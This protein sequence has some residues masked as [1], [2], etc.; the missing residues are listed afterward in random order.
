LLLCTHGVFFVGTIIVCCLDCWQVLKCVALQVL[1]M[2]CFRHFLFLLVL[3]LRKK[4]ANGW[5]EKVAR[6]ALLAQWKWDRKAASSRPVNASIPGTSATA[7]AGAVAGG[8]VSDWQDIRPTLRRVE[9]A[10]QRSAD[11]AAATG[12]ASGNT[13]SSVGSSGSSSGEGGVSTN[14]T[15]SARRKKKTKRAKRSKAASTPSSS[16]APAPA[17]RNTV[18][19]EVTAENF[20]SVVLES[21]VPVLLDVYADWCGPCKQLGPVLENAAI[22]SGGMFRLAKVNSDRASDLAQALGITGLPTVYTVVDGK[23]NDKYVS[24]CIPWIF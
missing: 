15:S 6:E 7:S 1:F 16:T 14:S 3:H 9:Q 18:V 23:F 21:P 5:A 10:T 12:T 22:K 13:S 8:V 20:Q 17:A 11:G 2:W 24:L 4:V 19:F